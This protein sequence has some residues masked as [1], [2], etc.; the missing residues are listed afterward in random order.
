M[1][2]EITQDPR[3]EDLTVLEKGMR[4]F[5]LS[6]FPDLP[7]ESED[8]KFYAFAKND[9]SQVVGGIK[10]TIFWN[11]LE[12]D[13]LWVAPEYRRKGIASQLMSEAEKLAVDHGAGV[14][15]LKTVKAKAF[16]ER[17]G[18]SVYGVLEDRPLGSLLYH[19]KK[20]LG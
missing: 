8:I 7:D 2:I 1:N 17:L 13:T 15:Y 19:M 11:G 18:Y 16:Y 20:R 14:A 12:I 9:T 5:E 10:A 3:S 4:D 6:V